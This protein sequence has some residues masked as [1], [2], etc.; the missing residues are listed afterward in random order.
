MKKDKLIPK[1]RFKEFENDEAWEQSKLSDVVSLFGGNAFSSHDSV[2]GGARWLKIAN[3]GTGQLKWNDESFLPISYLD[4]YSSYRLK[5]GDYVMALTRPILNHE[6]KVAEITEEDILLNQRVAKLIF[7]DDSKFGYQLLR[8]RSTVEMIENE[9]AGTDPPNLSVNTLNHIDVRVPNLAEQ[10]K[11]SSLFANLDN[12]ITLHQRKLKKLKE[13]KLAY[14]SEMFPEEGEKYPKRRFAGFTEPWELRKLGDMGDT[15][16]G[17]SGKTKED[18]GKGEAEFITY[19]N[20]FN[21][22]ISNIKLTEKVELDKKQNEVRYGDIF[23]T[24]SSETPEEVGM[25]SVWLDNREN[26]YLNSFC[27]GYRLKD[28]VDPFYM[29]YSLRS[30]PIRN[31]FILLAQGISRYNISKTKAMDIEIMLPKL[32]EQIKLGKFFKQLDNLIT[33]HQRKLEKLENMKKAYL[34]E[35]F[36]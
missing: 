27:F 10:E 17:L 5:I 16:T 3:V 9:L 4:E 36:V 28:K 33:L 22:P 13:L 23:F 35:M 11:I 20:V 6:L 19:L 30:N 26:V 14:L 8:K 32:D 21:N 1:R 29:A 25:S 24:T 7:T 31:Q 15:F 18:F 34:N 12:L 2:D